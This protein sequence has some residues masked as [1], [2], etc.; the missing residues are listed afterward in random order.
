MA[1]ENTPEKKLVI[2]GDSEPETIPVQTTAPPLEAATPVPVVT[3]ETVVDKVD[4]ETE[5]AIDEIAAAEQDETV[6][7]VIQ[8]SAEKPAKKRGRLRRAWYNW[9]HSPLKRRLTLAVL[10]IGLG[11]AFGI[12]TSR[13]FVLNNVG[14][15]ASASMVVLDESTQ[16]PLKNVEVVLDGQTAVTN[17][18]GKAVFSHL[19]MGK[20]QLKLQKR[21]F[22]ANER[23]IVLGWGSNPL[24]SLNLKP[25]GSQYQFTVIDYLS[26]KP[27][28]KAEAAV[29]ELTAVADEQG[30]VK[31][32]LDVTDEE[33]TV[34]VAISAAGYR[35]ETIKLDVASD[36][37]IKLQLVPAKSHVFISKR[38]GKYDVYKIDIDGKNEEKI[39]SGSGVEKDDLILVQHPTKD[40]AALV[41][42]RENVRD[43]DG[44]LLSTLTMIDTKNKKPTK[45][46]QSQRVQIVGWIGDRLVFVQIASN[47]GSE[48]PGR[49][50][51]MSYDLTSGSTKQL[52]SANYFNDVLAVG[53]TIFYAPSAAYAPDPVQ[54][55]KI[56][57]D[58]SAKQ[59]VF[60]Q[61][62]WNVYRPGY[63]KL[64][65]T[66]GQEWYEYQ[67]SSNKTTKLGGEPSN[68]KSRVYID[69]SARNQSLWVDQRDGKG[70]LLAYDVAAKA[71]KILHTQSGLNNPVQW[72]ND[73]A[74][75][76]RVN[77]SGETAD[78]ALSL[79]GG[80]PKKI[81]DVTN[82]A[83]VD[84]W[85]YY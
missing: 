64:I 76:F 31:L 30:I 82:T 69:N 53:S 80:E 6:D 15:R 48:D 40:F 79:N 47:A 75:I 17:K 1:T 4:P 55:Y 52:A 18:E 72:I 70:V 8:T 66:V 77:V 56:N 44:Y 71:D 45:I 58:G 23:T 24:P 74:V 22:A 16:Q 34:D 20:V 84:N 85:Y 7:D 51:L 39:L 25:V 62:V 27:I 49:H 21:A 26:G 43:N 54:F 61:E 83:G 37:P 60:D 59:T 68:L 42:T 57:A 11:A 32:T 2:T 3:P 28:A 78:Y 12:P 13:Y 50:Q 33:A 41:S 14:V 10:F 35:S 67:I 19:R 63:D 9:W 81:Q 46:A 73:S 38:S 36:A 5:Q 29:G 65:L